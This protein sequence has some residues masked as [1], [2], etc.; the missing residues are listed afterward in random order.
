[1]DEAGRFEGVLCP[2]DYV[3]TR[4]LPYGVDFN[5]DG[6]EQQLCLGVFDYSLAQMWIC[7]TQGIAQ[8]DG[9]AKPYVTQP[10]GGMFYPQI[11]SARQTLARGAVPTVDGAPVRLFTVVPFGKDAPRYVVAVQD[12]YVGVYDGREK[13][14]AFLWTPVVPIRAAAVTDAAAD[15][16]TVVL[17]T[18]GNLLWQLN[19]KE[20]PDK[21]A[22]FKA[23]PFDDR[24]TALRAIPGA[25][26][27]FLIA[28]AK[29]LYRA[30]SFKNIQRLA[31][32]GWQDAQVLP[33]AGGQEAVVAVTADGE[34]VRLEMTR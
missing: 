9:D 27:G 34:V 21:L 11:Y 25:P 22:S 24:A 30:D 14:W 7:M 4:L 2:G 33:T 15:H 10:N 20:R 31:V 12:T 32:G 29:G 8:L 1:V 28:G 17:C 16:L 5:G 6:R 19:W 3:L 18:E 23:I 26:G 13:K